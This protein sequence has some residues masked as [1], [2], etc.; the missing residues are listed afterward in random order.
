MVIIKKLSIDGLTRKI[1]RLIC[2]GNAIGILCS[3]ILLTGCA[4]TVP[5]ATKDDIGRLQWNINNLNSELNK[6]K[7]SSPSSYQKTEIDNKLNAIE[8]KQDATSRTVSDLL[9]QVQSLA[10]ELQI[11]NG[12]FEEARYFSEKSSTELLESKDMMM[13]KIKELDLLTEDLKKQLE[14]LKKAFEVA[15]KE[16]KKIAEQKK[17]SEPVKIPEKKVKKE[18]KEAE[19]SAK[20]EEPSVKNIYME[21]YQLFK[22]GK[23]AES[24]DKFLSVIK[25]YSEND[26]SD[27][28]RFWLGESYYKEGLYE[29]AILAYDELFKNNPES[30][31]VPG[32]MLK[33]G[34]AFYA[35]KDEKTGK[36]ILEKLIEKFPD[37]EP[38]ILAKKKIEKPVVPKKK[39]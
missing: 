35:L 37:S 10:S 36:L 14:E 3:L 23:T 8:E 24:R 4:S 16:K 6:I 34:L 5:I 38:A 33:Q 18:P 30:D 13:A 25:N 11:L 7:K 12:R 22:E 17:I 2:P 21:G 28:A 32:A 1:A 31:K 39:K 26:Y 19:A 27:N 15:E 9:I 20:K 29:D